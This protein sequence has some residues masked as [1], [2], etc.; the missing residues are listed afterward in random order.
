M[1]MSS[2]PQIVGPGAYIQKDVPKTSTI[3]EP[4]KWTIGTGP[5]IGNIF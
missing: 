2:T 3:T 4:P 5:K 1:Q